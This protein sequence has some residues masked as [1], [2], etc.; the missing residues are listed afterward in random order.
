MDYFYGAFVSF[1]VL[2]SL[3]KTTGNKE[4]TNQKREREILEPV[5][6]F[7]KKTELS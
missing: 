3:I 2:E 4:S 5:T 1:W 7:P 6:Q